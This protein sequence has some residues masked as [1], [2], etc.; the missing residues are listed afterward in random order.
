MAQFVRLKEPDRSVGAVVAGFPDDAVLT[1]ARDRLGKQGG[2]DA[3]DVIQRHLGEQRQLG[4]EL[5][6]QLFIV[7]AHPLALAANFVE[8]RQHLGQRHQALH[9]A[10]RSRRPLVQAVGQ[11]FHAV[12]HADRQRLA[13]HG[14][15][16]PDGTGLAGR[17][18]HLAGPVPVQ[19]VLAFF[20]EELH[21]ARIS[22]PGFQRPADGEV[23][24]IAGKR[25]G[26]SAELFRRV[27][28]RVGDQPKAVQ[29]RHPPIH[30]RV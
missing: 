7:L 13:A 1:Q 26:F 4:T 18:P 16:A 21:G 6:Q 29:R 27:G 14:A 5:A 24:Q 22:Q 30:R 8:F 19:V 9:A 12:H 11:G 10:R 20:G 28:I 17:Q 2:G 23:V 3:A 25:A 15:L